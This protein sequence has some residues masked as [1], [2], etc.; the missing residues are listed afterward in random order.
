MKAAAIEH[1]C[2]TKLSRLNYF[3]L[4]QLT[5]NHLGTK[6]FLI[7]IASEGT[8]GATIGVSFTLCGGVPWYSM[9][10]SF[11]IRCKT[12]MWLSIPQHSENIWCL[13]DILRELVTEEFLHTNF[14]TLLFLEKYYFKKYNIPLSCNSQTQAAVPKEYW[15]RKLEFTKR[16][17]SDSAVY[18]LLRAAGWMSSLN[19]LNFAFPRKACKGFQPMKQ[20]TDGFWKIMSLIK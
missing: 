2:H 12:E 19:W 10:I 6:R 13:F 1:K 4:S 17:L 8:R 14:T 3:L 5:W 9:N 7:F 11:D 20:H 15:V 16:C 18:R